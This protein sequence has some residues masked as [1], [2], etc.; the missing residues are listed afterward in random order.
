MTLIQ[1]LCQLLSEECSELSQRAS[2][3]SRFGWDEIQPGQDLNN[4]E[5]LM[6]E[7]VDVTVIYSL[8]LEAIGQTDEYVSIHGL[9]HQGKHHKILKFSRLS[10]E[11]GQISEEVYQELK[12]ITLFRDEK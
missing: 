10:V 7:K 5:R 12:S 6:G 3:L 9:K 8:I 4:F 1:Y 2:K 11:C